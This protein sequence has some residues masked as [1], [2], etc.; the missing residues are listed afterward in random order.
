MPQ[1]PKKRRSKRLVV[2]H[3]IKGNAITQG[4][5]G[6]RLKSYYVWKSMLQRCYSIK[7]HTRRP[8][9]IGCTVCEEW[10]DF[11]TF[12]TWFDANYREGFALDKDIL[13]LGNKVYSPATCVLVPQE[14]NSLLTDSGGARGLWPQGVHL[15][16]SGRYQARCCRYEQARKFLGTF[17]TPEEA[18]AIYRAYKLKHIAKVAA[19]YYANS[20]ITPE[21]RDALFRYDIPS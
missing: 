8:T 7:V 3:G 19:R 16:T 13:V 18:F 14:I 5:N 20:M 17:D 15:S 6:K 10:K 12:Q 9:Y 4:A 2:G 21:V 1:G 11:G